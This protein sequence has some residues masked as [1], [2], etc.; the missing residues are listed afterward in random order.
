MVRIMN[1]KAPTLSV[2][3]AVYNGEKY[4]RE[5]IESILTQTFADFEL[6]ISDNASSDGTQE[7]CTEYASGDPRI[8]YHRNATNIGGANNENQTFRFSRGKYF[9]WAAHDDVCEPTLFEKTIDLLEENPD[10]VLC[11]CQSQAID[12][13]GKPL[14][15][16]SWNKASA[17]E[18]YRRFAAL[19]RYDHHCEATYGVVRS[20]V[21]RRTRLQLNYTDSDRTLLAELSLYGRFVEIPEPLFRKRFHE[22]N[23]YDDWRGRM[24]WF[25]E[26]FENKIVFPHWLQFGD[27]F[28]TIGR[29]PLSAYQKARCYAAMVPWFILYGKSMAKDVLV[30]LKTILARGV[31]LLSGR[32]KTSE[33]SA[34]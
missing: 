11:Y 7:I 19:I 2:G 15:I 21:M 31:A 22:G 29:V 12:A 17:P 6:I 32:R 9:R 5:A 3:L 10:V 18:P 25:D 24:A 27:Y 13:E 1:E 30:A 4:L 23:V 20:E 16:K 34:P 14:G 33:Q 8:R 26:A 28:V